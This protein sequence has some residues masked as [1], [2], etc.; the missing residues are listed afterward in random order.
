MIFGE[1]LNAT[2]AAF[3]KSS[4]FLSLY[5]SRSVLLF[6]L[7]H[8]FG[9]AVYYFHWTRS[10]KQLVHKS[11]TFS[12]YISYVHRPSWSW[13]E[14]PSD[15]VHGCI[16]RGFG[17]SFQKRIEIIYHISFVIRYSFQFKFRNGT[18]PFDSIGCCELST[19][20]FNHGELDVGYMIIISGEN[21]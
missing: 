20:L 14:R 6:Q 21:S 17:F 19:F 1:L 4:I 8:L 7:S 3:P 11:R 16:V 5:L 9:C 13:Q 10:E 12:C 18:I 2:T 15:R